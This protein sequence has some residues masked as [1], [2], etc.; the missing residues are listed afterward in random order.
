MQFASKRLAIGPRSLRIADVLPAQLQTR[1]VETDRGGD[2]LVVIDV[3]VVDL[4]TSAATHD[5]GSRKHA[6]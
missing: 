5:V 2:N 4:P 3:V 6:A 1:G